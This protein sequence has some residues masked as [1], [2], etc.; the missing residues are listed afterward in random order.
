MKRILVLP[1]FIGLH[2]FVLLAKVRD[3]GRML[4]A[5]VNAVSLV[6]IAL[7]RQ[8]DIDLTSRGRRSIVQNT[9]G[10]VL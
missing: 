1:S 7:S 9:S 2:P 8:H 6:D 5:L 10:D 4:G 3:Y